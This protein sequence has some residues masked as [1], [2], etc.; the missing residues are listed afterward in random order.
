MTDLSPKQEELCHQDRWDFSDLRALFISCTLKRS[1][2]VSNTEG[3]ADLSMTIMRRTGVQV[4]LIRAVE[5]F[6]L[7]GVQRVLAAHASDDPVKLLDFAE[8]RLKAKGY[9]DVVAALNRARGLTLDEAA[10]IDGAT[11]LQLFRLVYIPL[12]MPSLV[13]IGTYAILLAWNEY[14]YAFLLL[15]KDTEITLPVAL[16]NF[17]ADTMREEI[18]RVVA[19]IP[20]AER[21]VRTSPTGPERQRCTPPATD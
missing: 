6:A 4:D 21:V 11:P 10:R 14:L 16:G 1:P 13:A 17:L 12:M 5:Q 8:Q 20:A 15:S 2:E 19:E 7:A 18:S 9:R 3:L